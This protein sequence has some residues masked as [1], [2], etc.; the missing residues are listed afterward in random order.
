MSH[1]KGKKYL[2]ETNT[3]MTQI[4]ELADKDFKTVK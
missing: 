4:L 3:R 2:I 1:S